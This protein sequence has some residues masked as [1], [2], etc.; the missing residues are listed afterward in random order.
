M[1]SS[2]NK[3]LTFKQLGRRFLGNP[4]IGTFSLFFLNCC[5]LDIKIFFEFRSYFKNSFSP[6]SLLSSRVNSV[7]LCTNNDTINN[8]KSLLLSE[9]SLKVHRYLIFNFATCKFW[10][11]F[12]FAFKQVWLSLGQYKRKK[13][14][15]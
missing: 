9:L 4:S 8:S 10:S 2:G 12:S 7:H 3:N 14:L 1:D 13:K 5:L 6:P 11:Y 15:Y